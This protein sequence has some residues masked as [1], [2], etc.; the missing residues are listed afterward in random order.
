MSI[1]KMTL[2]NQMGDMIRRFAVSL[3]STLSDSKIDFTMEQFAV[4]SILNEQENLT[5]QDIASMLSKDKSGVLRH[6][7]NLEKRKYVLRVADENDRRKKLLVITKKGFEAILSFEEIKKN[8]FEKIFKDLS[9]QQ[10]D[11]FSATLS[12]IQKNIK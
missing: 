3:Q 7:D 8:L 2:G 10:L 4:L 5:Q 12:I 9:Q 6:I 1:D 11:S